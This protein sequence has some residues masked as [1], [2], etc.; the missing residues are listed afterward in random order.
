MI[1]PNDNSAARYACRGDQY[2]N[3]WREKG[4]SILGQS[5]DFGKT[6]DLIRVLIPVFAASASLSVLLGL[7]TMHNVDLHL[8]FCWRGPSSLSAHQDT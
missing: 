4:L 2:V 6:K 3:R 5:D 7:Q 1:S 8:T